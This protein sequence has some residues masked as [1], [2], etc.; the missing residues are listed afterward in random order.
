MRKIVKGTTRLP[1]QRFIIWYAI[2]VCTVR[3]S[4]FSIPNHQRTTIDGKI[5]KNHTSIF[6]QKKNASLHHHRLFPSYPTPWCDWGDIINLS[7]YGSRSFQPSG[8]IFGKITE[9]FSMFPRTDKVDR[10]TFLYDTC[11][12]FHCVSAFMWN[13]KEARGHPYSTRRSWKYWI[14]TNQRK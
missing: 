9:T 14:M 5:L 1:Q 8:R 2:R 10:T 13:G 11:T 4:F 7:L 12:F 6:Q 3:Y